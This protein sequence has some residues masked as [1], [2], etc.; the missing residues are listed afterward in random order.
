MKLIEMNGLKETKNMKAEKDKEAVEIIRIMRP[1]ALNHAGEDQR[2][3]ENEE[4][5][6]RKRL[7]SRG[8]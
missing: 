6:D 2:A 4:N 7:S 5:K 8:N 3:G 1:N